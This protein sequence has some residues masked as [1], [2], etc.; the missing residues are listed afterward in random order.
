MRSLDLSVQLRRSGFDVHMPNAF[1][2]D[3]PVELSLPLMP[4]IAANRVD[5]EGELLD[6][7]VD[8]VDRALL[9]VFSIDLESADPRGVIDRRV[10]I[11][12][13]LAVVL[14]HQG[15]ELDVYLDL[16]A[17]DLFGVA[18]GMDGPPTDVSRKTADPVAFQRAVDA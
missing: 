17:R 18:T 9:V 2:L 12:T 10:L 14:C 8:E 4:A 15:Q 7:V 16:M 11:A 6:D 5:A 3:M 1:V 13:D